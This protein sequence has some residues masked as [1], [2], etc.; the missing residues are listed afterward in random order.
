MR[1]EIIEEQLT[2]WRRVPSPWPSWRGLDAFDGWFEGSS[3]SVAVDLRDD[4]LFQE[5]I[6]S[7]GGVLEPA[8]GAGLSL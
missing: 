7:R 4:P 2:D 6:R 1:G 8:D 5:E 3:R